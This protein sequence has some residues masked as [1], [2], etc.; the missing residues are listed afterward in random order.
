MWDTMRKELNVNIASID[1][2]KTPEY[3]CLDG[4]IQQVFRELYLS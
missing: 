1:Y 4:P 2:R 3:M